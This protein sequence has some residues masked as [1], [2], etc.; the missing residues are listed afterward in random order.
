MHDDFSDWYRPCTSGTEINLTGDLLAKRWEGV[1]KIAKNHGQ[2]VLDMV[3][4]A[5]GRPAALRR[6]WAS[7]RL[8]SR[9]PT[10]HFKCQGTTS[11]SACWPVRLCARPSPRRLTRRTRQRSRYCARSASRKGRSGASRSS[12][13][14]SATSTDGSEIYAG[15]PGLSSFN[16]PPRSSSRISRSSPPS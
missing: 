2:E 10:P 13:T 4:V 9:R 6:S 8:R 16:C 7:S 15:R 1:E 12:R 14:P 3:R 5:L 11:N